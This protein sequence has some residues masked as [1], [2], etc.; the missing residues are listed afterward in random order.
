[1]RKIDIETGPY[2]GEG[3]SY[4]KR[5]GLTEM[6]V[7]FKDEFDK[8]N[9]ENIKKFE[10]NDKKVKKII[11][12]CSNIDEKLQKLTENVKILAENCDKIINTLASEYISVDLLRKRRYLILTDFL[13]TVKTKSLRKRLQKEVAA[14][15]GMKDLIEP[16]RNYKDTHILL[17]Y[18]ILKNTEELDNYVRGK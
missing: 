1:M 7:T 13:G 9:E 11:K 2:D 18:K 10:E 5:D 12:N 6:A 3:M 8:Q 14:N 16:V 17:A 4:I 15:G